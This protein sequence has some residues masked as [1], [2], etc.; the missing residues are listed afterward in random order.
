MSV[1][2]AKPVVLAVRLRGTATDDSNV[3]KTMQ[4]LGMESAFSARL[5]ENNP[6][7]L[8][9]LRV[10]KNL[11]AWGEA[12][13]AVI[14]TLLR[15][16]A[17]R[18]AEKRVDDDF[19]RLF[20]KRQDVGELAKSL[21]AGEIPVTKLWGAGVKPMFRLHPPRGGFKRSIRRAATDGGEL[22]SRGGDINR[23]VQRMI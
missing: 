22:G 2:P 6:S 5:L 13:P 12:N 10:A 4:T 19:A 14:E 23:L 9:M 21:V 20:F 11:V 15:K 16:R 3:R 1:T 18:E 17:E 7:T 8:G